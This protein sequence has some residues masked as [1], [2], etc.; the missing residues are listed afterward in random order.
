MNKYFRDKKIL[1]SCHIYR[2]LSRSAKEKHISFH[3]P[4]HKNPKWDITELSFSDNL[5]NPKGCIKEAEQDISSL[6]NAKQ[7]FLLTDGSTCGIFCML[8]SLKQEGINS[9]AIPL[10]SHKS[11]YNAC[12]VLGISIFPFE[13]EKNE[14]GIEEFPC[15]SVIKTALDKAGA[16]LVVSPNYYGKT[17]NFAALRKLCDE[18]NKPLLVDGAHGGHLRFEK[19]LHP[20]SYADMWVDGV[21]KSLPALTQ[22]AVVSTANDNFLK[23]LKKAVDIFRTTSPSYPIMASVEY[24][25]K[26]PNNE[27]LEKLV[28]EFAKQNPARIQLHEDY[29]KLC[30]VFGSAAFK[31]EKYLEEHGVFAEFCDGY[32]IMF[33]LSPA[34]A[35]SQFKRLAKRLQKAFQI[36]PLERVVLVPAPTLFGV[37][38]EETKTELVE[39]DK[40]E[41]RVCANTCGLFPPCTPLI[42][43]GERVEREKIE[44]LKNANNTFGLQENK[45]TVFKV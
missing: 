17:A 10:S 26:F 30:A 31:A 42:L 11:V 34:T 12:S 8:Y 24:A 19:Q 14:T 2:M 20:S 6:L 33:Y 3:T 9:V 23:S 1:Q 18:Q 41:G 7:S 4:G 28:R 13:M 39:L 36:F 5:S 15:V 27:K 32:V 21:H 16:L 22:G 35:T 40:S 37:L 29:T 25:V 38:Q 44:L 43:K 45:M